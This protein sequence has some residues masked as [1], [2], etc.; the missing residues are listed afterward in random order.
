MDFLTMIGT[1]DSKT[2]PLCQRFASVGENEIL[3]TARN[4]SHLADVLARF[5]RSQ[6]YT[7]YTPNKL[8]N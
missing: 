3:R 4:L 2:V 1:F 8:G 6:K 7:F 5:R